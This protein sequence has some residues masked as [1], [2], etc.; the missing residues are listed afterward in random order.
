MAAQYPPFT[1][2]G[3]FT[4]AGG[5]TLAFQGRGSDLVRVTQCTIEVTGTPAQVAAAATARC[6]IRRNGALIAPMAPV[7]DVA[8]KPPEVWLWPGDV[9]TAEWSGAI[10]SVAGAVGNLVVLYDLGE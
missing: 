3:V 8:A 10:A 4:A 6:G 7:E 9:L 2:S 5:L 1:T